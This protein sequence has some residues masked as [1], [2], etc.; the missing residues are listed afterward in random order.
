[1]VKELGTLKPLE[2][3]EIVEIFEPWK[4]WRPWKICFETAGQMQYMCSIISQRK[5]VQKLSF[6]ELLYSTRTIHN[7]P[8]LC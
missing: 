7:A 6:D 5:L 2:R 4:M 1:M 8:E 3:G